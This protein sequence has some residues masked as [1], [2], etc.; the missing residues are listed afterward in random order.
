MQR[1]TVIGED[2]FIR[3]VSK[4]SISIQTNIQREISRVAALED[5]REGGSYSDCGNDDDDCPYIVQIY[6]G[7]PFEFVYEMNRKKA[8]LTYI[9]CSELDFLKYGQ[10]ANI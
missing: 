9:D 7:L 8:E 4:F 3:Q 5:P 2:Y 1:W 10:E 6:A